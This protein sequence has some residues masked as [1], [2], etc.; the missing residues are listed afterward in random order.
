MSSS[1][2]RWPRP[3]A[4]A[5]GGCLVAC[6]LLAALGRAHAAADPSAGTGAE[7]FPVL[8]FRVLHNTLLSAR[9]VEAAVYPHLGPERS[10]ADVQAARA[11]LEQAYRRAG[12]STV[13]VDI[14]EQS[15]EDRIVRLQ[16]TEG[17]LERV[18]VTGARYVMNR[19]LLASLP[20]LKSGTVPRFSDLQQQLAEL[21]RASA[22]LQVVP[23]LKPGAQPATVDVELK[24]KDTLPLHVSAEV[25]DRYTADTT[26][27]RI[28]L[29]LSYANLFQRNQSLSFQYQTAPHQ[30][31]NARV[32][33]ATWI[34]PLPGGSSL[35]LFAVKTDSDV[36]SLG[37]LA[38]LG[39]GQVYGTRFIV[40]LRLVPNELLPTLTFGVDF[41]KFD[42]SVLLAASPGLQTP[43]RYLNWSAAFGGTETTP[44][45]STSFNLG[46][47]FG[48]RDLL[49]DPAEFENKRFLAKPNYAYL[50]LD[51]S[52]ERPFIL[53]TRLAWHLLG[54]Y[55]TE[56]LISNEQFALGGADSVRGYLEAEALGDLGFSSALELRTPQL[57]PLLRAHARQAYAYVFYDGGVVSII[58][59]LPQQQ[60]RSSLRGWGLGLRLAGLAGLDAELDWA[61]P[62]VATANET[63]GDS[64]VHFYVRYGF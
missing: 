45:H 59:P 56:P 58:D 61:R 15:V 27:E 63:I 41:K 3:R 2:V 44:V 38:V 33:A 14:P 36:A 8:E 31:R 35:A 22:D 53:G 57:A 39:K 60:P 10:F 64:R 11:D 40:P 26:H 16:V 42:E 55:T 46:L 62:R 7:R 52:H 17:R 6:V 25:N 21:N 13:Y 18:R 5:C 28:N 24:V 9:Q 37:T 34:D 19:R 20:S 23:V 50:R 4:L 43:I 54:Q 29:N 47:N 32:W 30:P 12:Y 1:G 49:N 51:A 48:L